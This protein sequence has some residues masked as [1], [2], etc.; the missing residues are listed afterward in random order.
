MGNALHELV[1]LLG[2][3]VGQQTK[4]VSIVG[5]IDKEWPVQ[6]SKARLC[7]TIQSTEPLR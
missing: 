4:L 3:R 1:Q 2:N 5:R 6:A 7:A